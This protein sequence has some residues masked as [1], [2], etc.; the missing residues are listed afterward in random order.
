VGFTPQLSVAVGMYRE[1]CRTKSGKIV[2]PKFAGS[3]PKGSVAREVSLGFE[4]AGPPTTLW[5]TFMM[6]ALAGQPAKPLAPEAGSGPP[7]NIVP[8]PTPTP[9]PTPTEEFPYED[10]PDIVQGDDEQECQPGEPGCGPV[11]DPGRHEL[12]IGGGPNG[13]DGSQQIPLGLGPPASAP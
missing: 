7:Q 9:K 8:S 3:C 10:F 4:G 6:E 2:Q 1:Q 5:R 11:E 13:G 12:D